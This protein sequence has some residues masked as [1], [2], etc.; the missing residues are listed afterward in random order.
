MIWYIVGLLVGSVFGIFAVSL[1][2]VSARADLEAEVYML[3]SKL[4]EAEYLN[5]P[6][7]IEGAD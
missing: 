6:Y 3:R 5:R 1:C 2:R 7:P 4:H